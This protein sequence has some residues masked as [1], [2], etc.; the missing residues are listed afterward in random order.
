[1][2][3][4]ASIPAAEVVGVHRPGRWA[5]ARRVA[6]VPFALAVAGCAAAPAS[7]GAHSPRPPIGTP[8]SRSPGSAPAPTSSSAATPTAAASS[9]SIAPP[10]AASAMPA[11]PV[12]LGPAASMTPPPA[13]IP[14]LRFTDAAF[15]SAADGWASGVATPG[16]GGMGSTR[17]ATGGVIEATTDGGATWTVQY[18]G[19]DAVLA[20]AFA[21]P[22]H[23]WAIAVPAAS[24]SA[25][26]AL[27]SPGQLAGQVLLAT[28]DGGHTWAAV[29]TDAAGID[30]LSFSGAEH[31]FAGRTGCP[32]STPP[33]AAG[34]GG[35]L[36]RTTDGG[37]TWQAVPSADPPVGGA[38]LPLP[39]LAV[40]AA[41]ANLWALEAGPTGGTSP[42]GPAGAARVMASADGG[43]SWSPGGTLP[44]ADPGEGA[45]AVG[46]LAFSSAAVGYASVYALGSC[47][48]AGCGVNAV[49]RT[50]DGGASWSV[51]T[52]GQPR[53]NFARPALAATSAE[54]L[55]AR[56]VNLAACAGPQT[57]LVRSTN[58]GATWNAATTWSE[59]G[60]VRLLAPPGGAATFWA[61]SGPALLRSADGGATWAQVLPAPAPTAAVEFLSPT[62]GWGV[63]TV[64]DPGA[65]L[66]T[67]DGG[68][69]WSVA[70]SFAG[71]E[72]SGVS[73][74]SA[75][76]G[77]VVGATPAW[78]PQSGTG[79][80]WHTAD[81]GR[82]WG[83]AAP[84]GSGAAAPPASPIPNA[85][86]VRFLSARDGVLIG[87][88]ASSACS[89]GCPPPDLFTSGDAGATW[90]SSGA[91]PSP[92]GLAAA[93]ITSTGAV[94]GVWG[95]G[96]GCGPVLREGAGAPARWTALGCLS[97]LSFAGSPQVQFA[98]PAQ[99]YAVLLQVLRPV[100]PGK[101]A[102]VTRPL[103]LSTADGGRTWTA[104]P[105][106]LA[107]D[108]WFGN[109][110]FFLDPGHGWLLSGGAVWETTDG[111][112]HWTGLAF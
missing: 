47:A 66:R 1:M 69:T 48:M 63:G 53:C 54:A 92:G 106:P 12:T 10:P 111:G 52:A 46:A 29:D 77:W 33:G 110:L 68:R 23:G 50:A 24:I 56:G 112:A 59:L 25:C 57:T 58:G 65:V 37:R 13:Y 51:V 28:T 35:G 5:L 39:V 20:L 104:A 64:S 82:T 17:T 109:S 95:G 80:L 62:V 14:T 38:G 81:G 3:S 83:L 94:W 11:L 8:G 16:C 43:A 36:L 102:A 87:L 26:S 7:Q 42:A 74:A 103:L 70:A 31:G 85:A 61:V 55:V 105:L 49:F 2:P 15:P 22:L 32:G 98:S 97:G 73:F 100:D 101:R 93:D 44:L 19:P 67:S 4:A 79:L 72:L 75:R 99:G 60:P 45:G 27:P 107:A 78:D 40:T 30:A 108:D 90:R 86:A 96:A 21:D 88:G 84:A 91:V 9:S 6:A 71:A 41:G 34:C 76:D 89:S 18:Q